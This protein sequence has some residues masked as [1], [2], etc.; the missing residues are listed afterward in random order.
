MSEPQVSVTPPVVLQ[1]PNAAQ[2]LTSTPAKDIT[3]MENASL[4]EKTRKPVKWLKV[5]PFVFILAALVLAAVYYLLLGPAWQ[6]GKYYKTTK[7]DFSN[8]LSNF[9]KSSER[10]IIIHN[11]FILKMLIININIILIN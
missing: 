11:D 6:S 10:F 3:E 5:L 4:S 8:V 1:V 9:K 2:G 7:E